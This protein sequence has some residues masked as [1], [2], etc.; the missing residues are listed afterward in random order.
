[1]KPETK[2]LL[3]AILGNF[4]TRSNKDIQFLMEQSFKAGKGKSFE[5]FEVYLNYLKR[6]ILSL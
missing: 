5:S 4:E 2:E 1:M 6:E 3:A